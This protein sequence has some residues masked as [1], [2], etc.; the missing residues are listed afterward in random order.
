MTLATVHPPGNAKPAWYSRVAWPL[1]AIL[2]VQAYLSYRLLRL[3]TA[4]VDEAT[5]LYA[6]HQEINH[7]IH[8]WP[9][10]SYATYFSGAPTIYPPIGAIADSFGGL[11][12]ARALSGAFML[13]ATS[14]L[15]LT[16]SRLY[17]RR[18][19]FAGC[20][21]FVSLG[22]T[23]A[24]G[25]FATYDAMAFSILT[26][27]VYCAV[28][29]AC[30]SESARWWF[31]SAALLALA[32]ATKYAT[33][34]YD[35]FVVSVGAVLTYRQYGLR[36]ALRR[37]AAAV[38]V[39]VAFVAIGLAAG[40]VYY[41]DGIALTTVSRAS[42]GASAASVL[43]HAWSW[44]GWVVLLAAMSPILALLRRDR[45]TATLLFALACA[46]A[47]APLNQA[48]IHTL[49]SLQKHVDFGAWFACIAFGYSASILGSFFSSRLVR[50]TLASGLTAALL[51]LTASA[52]FAQ[53]AAYFHEWPDRV[54]LARSLAPYAKPGQ[55]QY[56]AEEYDVAAYYL[57]ARVHATQWN[58][59]WFFKYGG[60]TGIPAYQAAVRRHYFTAI[61]L[62]FG[63]TPAVDH[64]IVAA[65]EA[66]P[67][68]CGY[69][70]VA[71]LPYQGASWRGTFT[72][73]QY[74]GGAS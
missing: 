60:L 53:S 44:A 69:R 6:G 2:A 5:Y 28:R 47:A 61:I 50:V 62:D 63:D 58:D 3:N 64:A 30:S 20:A 41:Y 12:A 16:C 14:M 48:R 54:P 24:L 67:N 57:G 55:D 9:T 17:G 22:S 7:W 38:A 23:Q 4:F 74:Q 15:H 32:N 42:A 66:C 73:W 56:L 39:T 26:V 37:S 1:L 34:L 36:A 8:G 19:A 71:Q 29:A 40:G 35:P 68:Q 52:G 72:I 31:A 10:P 33:G 25:S 45:V 13:L 18:A 43:V 49:A 46:G 27:A 59:T 11:T 51:T 65:M 21:A 70:A